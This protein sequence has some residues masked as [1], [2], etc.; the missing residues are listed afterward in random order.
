V[1]TPTLIHQDFNSNTT[2]FPVVG[3]YWYGASGDTDHA[4]SRCYQDDLLNPRLYPLIGVRE[5]LRRWYVI[6]AHC[7]W[8]VERAHG[9]LGAVTH[10]DVSGLK[11]VTMIE[12]EL[13]IV[14]VC[15]FSTT[16]DWKSKP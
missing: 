12:S 15:C 4:Q 3:D 6:I 2:C 11:L 10:P 5:V 7:Q 9:V 13:R 16:D 8:T 1:S 14:S